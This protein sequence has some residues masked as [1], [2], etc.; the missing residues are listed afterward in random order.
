MRIISKIR[1]YYDNGAMWGVDPTVIY[2]RRPQNIDTDHEWYS[3]LTK[4]VSSYGSA[5]QHYRLFYQDEGGKLVYLDFKYQYVSFIV[6][7]NRYFGMAVY[8]D[9]QG[10]GFYVNDRT[11]K[12]Y[13][14]KEDFLEWFKTVVPEKYQTHLNMDRF[15]DNRFGV[16]EIHERLEEFMLDRRIVSV[17]PC[18][19]IFP[20]SRQLTINTDSLQKLQVQRLVDATTMF[21][22]IDQWISQMQDPARKMVEI[23]DRDKIVKHGMDA[24]SFRKPKQI[25]Q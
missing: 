5:F 25:K 11:V 7:R 21:H 10:G 8:P 1:D 12:F 22:N 19:D 9:K 14:S 2:E 6:G 17:T 23:S 13:Y 24:T 18:F 4:Y 15:M 16:K 3:F 20:F